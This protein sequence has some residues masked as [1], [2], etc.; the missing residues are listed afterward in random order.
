VA[1]ANAVA[2]PLDKARPMRTTAE[3]RPSAA[4]ATD[5]AGRCAHSYGT[6]APRARGTPY[7]QSCWPTRT[8]R[9]GGGF[10][11]AFVHGTQR[12]V[13]KR[14]RLTSYGS[15]PS[16][17]WQ[18]LDAPIRAQHEVHPPVETGQ[19][20]ITRGLIPRT[21]G[22]TCTDSTADRTRSADCTGISRL[23]VPRPVPR[24]SH[25]PQVATV[26]SSGLWPGLSQDH[27]RPATDWPVPA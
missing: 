16:D 26:E 24:L 23:P 10:V 21:R 12:D 22:V 5:G 9:P 4:T 20:R 13:L 15:Q 19:R 17:D 14:G 27:E 25:R 18:R 7:G 3:Y 6:G 2:K 8:S 1:V 11:H